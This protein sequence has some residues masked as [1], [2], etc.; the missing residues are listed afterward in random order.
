MRAALRTASKTQAVSLLV[1]LALAAFPLAAGASGQGEGKGGGAGTIVCANCHASTN[2]KFG[3]LGAK[4]RYELSGHKTLEDSAYANGQGCQ[5]C[6]TNEGFI[7]FTQKGEPDPNDFVA[8]ASQP[9]CSTCHAPHEKGDFS[10]RR[11][12]PVTLENGKVFDV[13][14]GNLCA[15]CHRATADAAKMVVPMPANKI[16]P[17]WGSHHGPQA[18]IV[19]GTNAYEFPG[20][21]YGSSAHKDIVNDGCISCHMS[22]PKGRAA[23]SPEI[24]GHSFQI[25]GKVHGA[26]TLNLSA[27]ISCHRDVSQVRGKIVFSIMAQED[28]DHNGKKEPFELE[29]QG[30]LERFVN[31]DGTGLLQKLNPPFYKPDGSFNFVRSDAL[32]PVDE[33]AA[34][35]NYRMIVDDKSSGIH[36][37]KYVIQVLYDTIQAMDPGFDVSLRPQ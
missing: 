17:F 4:A 10:L 25:E 23:L 26:D 27:C 6:H 33:V 3:I 14:H 28:Y 7:S 34:F 22:L 1:I 18:D 30:L 36:N 32:R 2:P 19:M 8:E 11:I 20:K 12:S 5:K 21:K 16:F 35:Y 24:G 29:V 13:G 37:T 15:T 9:G 31:K